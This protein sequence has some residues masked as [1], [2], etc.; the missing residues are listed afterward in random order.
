MFGME[1]ELSLI[2][3][4]CSIES[5]GQM[6]FVVK[7]LVKNNVRFIGGEAYKP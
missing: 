5:Y 1:K 6:E 4:P 7:V 2:A 3:G